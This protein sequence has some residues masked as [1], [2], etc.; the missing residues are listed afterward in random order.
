MTMRLA[1]LL[2]LIGAATLQAQ[3]EDSVKALETRR[4]E[5]LLK[6]DTAALSRMMAP[7][8]IE[9]SRLGQVRTGADN[10]RDIGAGVLK[11]TSVKYDSL[12]VRIY[13]DVA[14][15]RGI[16]DNTGSMR[17]FPF[18]GK[19][20]YTRVFV[21]RDGRWLAVAMQQTVMQ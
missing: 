19:I 15:L 3:A 2:L 20:R 16:A 5:A 8:F 4:G 17:G 11:L 18:S 9:I 7:E 14:V 21:K 13:G 1:G 12:T 6:A 10:L